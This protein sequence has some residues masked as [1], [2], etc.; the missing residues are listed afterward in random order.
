MSKRLEPDRAHFEGGGAF[1]MEAN[2]AVTIKHIRDVL[3]NR[4]A[5]GSVV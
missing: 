5:C 1:V 3:L 4:K 2:P